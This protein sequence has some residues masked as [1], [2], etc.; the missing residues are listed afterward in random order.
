MST[1]FCVKYWY[2]VNTSCLIVFTVHTVLISG[3]YQGK[4]KIVQVVERCDQAYDLRMIDII[5]C[6][7]NL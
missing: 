6:E 2:G 3:A 5:M 4:N 1:I 7:K